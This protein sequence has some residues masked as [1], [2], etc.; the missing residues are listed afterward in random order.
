M[1]RALL[2]GEGEVE[3]QGPQEGG[4]GGGLAPPPPPLFGTIE[5]MIMIKLENSLV[6]D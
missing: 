6:S 1:T 3:K 2:P 4:A 5:K